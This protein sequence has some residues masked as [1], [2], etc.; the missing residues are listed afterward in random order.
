MKWWQKEVYLS[1][2]KNPWINTTS[3]SANVEMSAY[4]MLTYL[5]RGLVQD[6]L[7][8]ANWLLNHQNSLGGFAS[9]QDT[10][11]GI[12]ALARLAEV[13]QT[14]NV[15]VTIN[16]SHNGKDAIPPVHITS[17]NALVLQKA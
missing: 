10:V 14:S 1:E 12:Y 2:S 8:I 17:E 11:V 13:L 6:A 15:D 3:R 5:E 4:A 7:P 9:T 16:F